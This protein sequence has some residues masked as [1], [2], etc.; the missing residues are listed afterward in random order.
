MQT[1]RTFSSNAC[2]LKKAIMRVHCSWRNWCKLLS[3]CW[4]VGKGHAASLLS[5]IR[6]SLIFV[7]KNA[8]YFVIKYGKLI[9]AGKENDSSGTSGEQQGKLHWERISLWYATYIN[10]FCSWWHIFI[11]LS[12]LTHYGVQNWV[13]ICHLPDVDISDGRAKCV[14]ISQVM[15]S[16]PI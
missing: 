11:Y 4:L 2:K 13:C 1:F 7:A 9:T 3:Q 14:I 10:Q 5:A 12:S 6:C 15:G 8:R 16:N